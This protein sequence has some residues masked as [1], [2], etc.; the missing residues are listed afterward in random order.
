MNSTDKRRIRAIQFEE[1]MR[2]RII[3]HEYNIQ[4]RL[5]VLR[6]LIHEKSEEFLTLKEWLDELAKHL[7]KLE[8]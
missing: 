7:D 1:L 6:V 2:T 3:K 8:V 4:T 5:S